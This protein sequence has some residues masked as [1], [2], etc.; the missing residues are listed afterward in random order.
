MALRKTRSRLKLAGLDQWVD[1]SA[2]AESIQT[3]FPLTTG[4]RKESSRQHDQSATTAERTN[5][6]AHAQA[7]EVVRARGRLTGN[8]ADRLLRETFRSESAEHAQGEAP[9]AEV[10]L[11]RR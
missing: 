4:N 1:A 11:A 2:G 3:A 5:S 10:E 7:Q 9:H 8:E 6:A